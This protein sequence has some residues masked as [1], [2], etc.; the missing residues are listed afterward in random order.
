MPIRLDDCKIP[1]LLRD[2][3]YADFR[4]PSQ[5]A[6][7]LVELERA[8][9]CIQQKSGITTFYHDFADVDCW[10]KLFEEANSLDLVIMY[11]ATWR[12]TY[13]KHVQQ[14]LRRRNALL[15]VVLPDISDTTLVEFYARKLQITNRDMQERVSQARSDFLALKNCGAV[16]IYVCKRYLYHAMYLFNGT[17]ILALYSFKDER[18]PTPA[19]LVQEGSLLDFMRREFQW[20]VTSDSQTSRVTNAQRA[21]R[22][23]PGATVR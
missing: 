15:R 13:L 5:Y 16:E 9:S 8:L 23:K 17:G 19:F 1:M 21:K 2:K 4:L 20:L 6:I 22:R 7:G 3:R 10:G 18:T 11:S 14:L 12:N